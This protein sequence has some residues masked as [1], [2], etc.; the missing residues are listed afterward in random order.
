M[1][2]LWYQKFEGLVTKEVRL[3][4]KD[5]LIRSLLLEISHVQVLKQSH[6]YV[7]ITKT[8]KAAKPYMNVSVIALTH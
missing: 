1:T 3:K 2:S 5:I 6:L 7:S 8:S 4:Y